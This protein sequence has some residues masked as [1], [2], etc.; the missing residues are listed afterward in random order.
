MS[1]AVAAGVVYFALVFAAGFVLGALRVTALEPR[2]G[3]LAA[4]AVEL[5]AMLT[6]SWLACGWSLRRLKVAPRV[7][8]RAVMGAAAFALL[9]TAE[10]GLS[11]IA[12]A[13]PLAE[14]FAGFATPAGA[15]GLAGQIA[16]ALFPLLR[17]AAQPT[18]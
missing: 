2:L 10:A 18:T 13:R 6:V 14:F 8:D 4:V 11:M 9:M 15:L 7:R 1:K 16:F 5:P 12:F 3:G 17:R